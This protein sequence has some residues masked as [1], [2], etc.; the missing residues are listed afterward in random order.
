MSDILVFTKVGLS[1]FDPF[2]VFG[3]FKVLPIRVEMAVFVVVG[4]T[5]SMYAAVIG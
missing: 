1:V 2:I 5:F 4:G 3:L